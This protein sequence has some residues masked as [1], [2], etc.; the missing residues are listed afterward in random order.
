MSRHFPAFLRIGSRHYLRALPTVPLLLFLCLTGIPLASSAALDKSPQGQDGAPPVEIINDLNA[1]AVKLYRQGNYKEALDVALRAREL[2]REIL[3][4]QHPG[5]AD[6]LDNLAAIFKATGEY[7]KAEPILQQ[8]LQIRRKAL[9]ENDPDFVFSL[10]NLAGLYK[11]TG[12]YPDSESLYLRALET[13]RANIGE[14]TPLFVSSLNNLASLYKAMGDYTKVEPLYIKARDILRKISAEDQPEYAIVISNLAHLYAIMGRSSEAESLYRQSLELSRKIVGEEHPQYARTLNNLASLYKDLGTYSRAEPLYRQALDLLSSKSGKN[15]PDAAAALNN[16]AE[17]Y[18]DMGDFEKAESLYIRAN[19]I[20]RAVYGEKHPDFASGLN[21]LAD[22]YYQVGKFDTAKKL[23]EQALQIHRSSLGEKHPDVALTMQNLAVL[24]KTIGKYKEAESLYRQALGIWKSTFGDRHPNVAL[25]LNN[26]GALYH[27]M[28][29]YGEA[30]PLY[31]QALEM[32]TALLGEYHPDV[33]A[34][35]NSLAALKAASSRYDDALKLMKQ[36]Q[37]INDRLIRNVFSI[38][39]ENQRLKYISVLSGEMDAFLSLV[40]NHLSKSPAAVT[41]G[42][43]LVLKRKAI[44]AE[45]VAAER[46]AILGG[47]YPDLEPSLR[48]LRTLRIQIAQKMMSGPGPEG[49]AAHQEQ[50]SKWNEDKERIEVS[51]AAKIPEVNLEKRLMDAD[52]Q[53]VAKALPETAALVEY[54]RFNSFDFNAA[55]SKGQPQWKPPRYLA[56]VMISGK[57]DSISLIDLGSADPIDRMISDFRTSITGEKDKPSGRG[58]SMNSEQEEKSQSVAALRK[59]VLD[60]VLP[61]L[62][63]LQRAF[64][65]PDGNLYR[66]SFGALPLG[67]DRFVIDDYH[68]SYIGSGR[69]VLRFGVET[70]SGSATSLVTADPDYD[71]AGTTPSGQPSE[72]ISAGKLSRDLLRDAPK[73]Q[74]L[75]GTRTE[76]E[77]IAALLGVAPL[78]G[79]QASKERLKSARSPRIMHIATHGF[80]LPDQEHTTVKGDSSQKKQP[81][82]LDRKSSPFLR[83]MESPLLRS[84]LVLAGANAWLGGK[85]PHGGSDDGILTGEDASGLDLLSTELVVLSACETGLGDIRVGEGVFGLRRAFLMAGAKTLVMSLWKVP[86]TQTQMLMEDFYKR[87]LAGAPRSQALREAQLSIKE[88]FPEPFYWA[89]FICQGD[90]GPLPSLRK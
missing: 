43:D 56:F 27:A 17:L 30:E 29:K 6:A 65:A 12:R 82:T 57:P 70:G 78:L 79:P 45:A 55:P 18:K 76:G 22:L 36:A 87:M 90:P 64:F 24:Y 21:N 33:A 67:S 71:L 32:R 61:A 47:R 23:Y 52:R 31:R 11:A 74:R 16:L 10:N 25:S 40:A 39:S 62:K 1:G 72:T 46:D 15:S 80:F 41:A 63:G 7:D 86:D 81:D 42:F 84:G 54:V 85:L 53:A 58:I 2:S 8:A 77:H 49:P 37:D 83:C 38:A 4:E 60:P 48:E 88:E 35:M 20:R 34:S 9:G 73:F 68:I 13:I 51:L 28:G 26:L 19:D 69:D 14:D 75:P 66:L 3:G 50:L 89:A 5:F 44:V 59:A